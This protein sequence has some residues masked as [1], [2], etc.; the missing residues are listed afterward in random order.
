[1]GESLD[2]L[3]TVLYLSPSNEA[4]FNMCPWASEGCASA[5][6]GHST[7]HL[8]FDSSKLARIGKTIWLK[9]FP[10]H[11]LSQLH[12]EIEKHARKAQRLGMVAAVRLNGSSDVLW[13]KHGIPQAHPDV[14]FY[15]Y[16]KAPLRARSVLPD[17]YHVLFSVSEKPGS[18][19]EALRWIA[20]GRNA[21]VVIGDEEGTRNGS[22]ETALRICE[23]GTFNGRPAISGDTHDARH[24]DQPGSF[25]VLYAKGAAVKDASGFVRRVSA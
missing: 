9:Y 2:I 5:C 7:G 14:V 24:L 23:E 11:F 25:V 15:D 18:M 16:T 10:D 8:R 19:D 1:M 21:A 12:K 13:E 3:T 20:S 17:N 6:L 4:G 22:K